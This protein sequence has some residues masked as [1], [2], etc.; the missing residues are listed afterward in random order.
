M[1]GAASVQRARTRRRLGGATAVGVVAVLAGSLAVAT[2]AS[3]NA[4]AGRPVAAPAAAPHSNGPV[5]QRPAPLTPLGSVAP[6]AD[7][8]NRPAT[9]G[10]PA[11]QAI[12]PL[13]AISP[14]PNDAPTVA[15]AA[16]PQSVPVTPAPIM[17]ATQP[18]Q[19]LVDA[20]RS[21]ALNTMAAA[22]PYV[23]GGAPAI[24]AN[25]LQPQ[26][27]SAQLVDPGTPAS[28]TQLANALLSGN[29]P[30]DLPVDPLALLQKLPNGVPQVT[31]R[32][33]SES[34]TKAASCTISLP[35]GVPALVNVT[36][37][38]TAASPDRTPDVLADL[39]P[40]VSLDAIVSATKKL[41]S[42]QA[43]LAAAKAS[44]T[45]LLKALLDPKYLLTHPGALLQKLD[46]QNLVASLTGLVQNELQALIGMV[47]VGLGLLSVRT[48]TSEI[49]AGQPLAAHV[50]AVYD[51]PGYH[52]L[53]IGYDGY[54]RGT[55]LSK[56]T[57]GIFTFN[58]A[59][60]AQGVYDVHA[61]MYN[62]GAASALA[63]TAGIS[64]ITQ[65]STGTAFD[66]T[67]ASARFSPVPVKFAA[68]ALINPGVE[69][70]TVEAQVS[71]RSQ[72][73]ALV[74]ANRGSGGGSNDQYLQVKIDT[75][76]N[77]VSAT[78]HR[79]TS[80]GSTDVTYRASS[81]IDD[82]LFANYQFGGTTLQHALQAD[83][84]GVPASIDL[85]ISTGGS[86]TNFGYTASSSL[87][88]LALGFYDQQSTMS[89]TSGPIV[90]RGALTQLPTHITGVID[91]DAKHVAITADKPLGTA[92][93]QA[94]FK[95]GAYAPLP[96]DHA[97][98]IGT[99]K[100]F[101]VDA[102]ISGFQAVDLYY[103]DHPRVTTTFSPGGQPFVAAGL[104]DDITKFRADI[105]NI[106]A[107]MSIDVDPAD[108]TAD[109]T[110][111]TTIDEIRAAY[112]NASTGPSIVGHLLGLPAHVH[113]NWTL[114]SSPHI[115]YE[116]TSS[117]P[118]AEFFASPQGVETLAPLGNDYLSA[119]V[120]DIP[121]TLDVLVDIANS[122]VEGNSSGPVGDIVVAARVPFLGQEWTAV[123]ELHQ[124]PALF[125][126]DFASG[127]YDF[128]AL[129]GP[130]G[131]AS[132]TVSNHPNP[133]EPT[134]PAHLALH[135]DEVSG[136]IDA[137]ASILNLT[138]VGYTHSAGG[139]KLTLQ[140]DEGTNPMQIDA[141]VVLKANNVADTELVA[142]GSVTGLPSHLDITMT[143]G[144]IKYTAD[145][146]LGIELG[147]RAGK[148]KALA[149]LGAPLP[150]NGIAAVV[151]TC[152]TGP[153]CAT[154]STP[155]CPAFTQCLGG[156]ANISLAGLP[157][158]VD[159][160]TG[161]GTVGFTDYQ[162]AAGALS[163]Y[164]RLIGVLAT[165]P[166]VSALATL[167]DLPAQLDFVAGPF[168]FGTGSPATID[169]GYHASAPLGTLT[170]DVN[171]VTTNATFPVL[172]ANATIAEL[173][174]SMHV[175]GSLGDVNHITVTDSD[176]ISSVSATVTNATSGYLTASIT[177]VPKTMD[178]V[179][180][181]P[182]SHAEATM[183]SPI[184]AINVL[185]HVPYDGRTWS[186]FAQAT[187]IPGHFTADFGGG[188]FGFHALSGRL[189]SA[190]FAV[191][192]H[193]GATVPALTGYL[194]A[195]YDQLSGDLDGGARVTQLRTAA[196]GRN[197]A[198]NQTFDLDI[199][200]DTVGLD[201]DVVQA[202]NGARDTRFSVGGTLTTPNTV[203]VD[204][205]DSG[206]IVYQADQSAA[207]LLSAAVGKV[208]A[209]AGL[210]API[211]SQGVAAR[212]RGCSAGPG[213]AN[214]SGVF[215]S[216]F[217]S[218][219]GAV[220]N[221]NLPGLPTKVDID[222]QAGT[223]DLVGLHPT[224][225][226]KVFAELDGLLGGDLPRVRALA[227]IDGLP[228]L[229][230]LKVGPFGADP[231]DPT[232]FRAGYSA[233]HGLGHLQVD[234]DADTT[235]S[236]GTIRGQLI[237]SNL[238][239]SVSVAGT[240][241]SQ[242]H[243]DVVDPGGIGELR[244][245]AT[246]TLGGVPGSALVDF[247]DIPGAMHMDIGSADTAQGV[248]APQFTYVGCQDN[249]N[250]C[251]SPANTLDGL[252]Q[253]DA[254]LSANVGPGSVGTNGAFFRF[255]NLGGDT[256][257][258]LDTANYHLQLTSVPQT[259]SFQLGLNIQIGDIPNQDFSEQ[260]FDFLDTQGYVQGHYGLRP[261]HIGDIEMS[262]DNLKSLLLQPGAAPFGLPALVGLLFPGVSGDYG[263]FAM[264][265]FDVDVNP[266]VYVKIH[267]SPPVVP[268][269][270]PVD[271]T[272]PSH[273]DSFFFHKYDMNGP[274]NI[275]T[276]SFIDV[277]CF[278]VTQEP[279]P[280]G[281][282]AN[283]VTLSGSDGP[284]TF[285][286][287]DYNDELPDLLVNVLSAY[288]SPFGHKFDY[289][290]DGC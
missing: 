45:N 243:I 289:N 197:A 180:D 104:I 13:P 72:L 90:A 25:K 266:D 170:V 140:A 31:Y 47:N 76:P 119:A 262:V 154:D 34:A 59:A 277:V 195:H 83:A 218:C 280:R 18:G 84:V 272:L 231:A 263:T 252:V 224:G 161:V 85:G 89:G 122:H 259:D 127:N 184:G 203:H 287:I 270:D 191:T 160:D 186:A 15:R 21:D 63:V 98:Y 238:P 68:H 194:T 58:P 37:N 236:L 258:R 121:T 244:V 6:G 139:Q 56:G 152:A 41:T 87:D 61:E 128:H 273:I 242:N 65:D 10:S 9:T 246:A 71:N 288:M 241:G 221:V 46:L 20:A 123:G 254:R 141:D 223:V 144:T 256:K 174:A 206:H 120:T 251:T 202:A 240:F 101:G 250:P 284:Q 48:G 274:G 131:A 196:Y 179:V 226:L 282:S 276:V 229:L 225:T 29:L 67:V 204:I 283:G 106:P 73:D 146:H 222:T 44:L 212:A 190:T 82:V 38:G 138:E 275:L 113:A 43:D 62:G 187:T 91:T 151:R 253:V 290:V 164:L 51:I 147:I 100:A 93:L 207:L 97:T 105:S 88:T 55:G 165:V 64:S 248:N 200:A 32:I 249:S 8:S 70:D 14:G 27:S 99:G 193:D 172:R 257:V 110:A 1:F 52:R 77:T 118:F 237:A 233:S 42:D 210:G 176:A 278:N 79:P 75:L 74:F 23:S 268:D 134:S 50:W 108:G 39:V 3:A 267:V 40:A 230:D 81:T 201:A 264:N 167:S 173:P 126:A 17:L 30:P 279:R 155:F 247:T 78:L 57:L 66:P 115:R 26:V 281:K 208:A 16:V 209:L 22:G 214:D 114:G 53:S 156:V 95:L 69:E 213:C 271:Y 158:E 192:N 228:P 96:G 181:V 54:R 5:S 163:I 255:T 189:G 265:M 239:Q 136:D 148:S 149:G 135:Y 7:G 260:I 11:L 145:K 235:S 286:F 86:T 24:D 211:Y 227:T 216:V 217:S 125:T 132:L 182:N 28:L 111:S 261:S 166:D 185:A 12:D 220:A 234:A 175:H 188:S 183:S 219:F 232:K 199:G 92:T 285:N 157:T 4:P 137:S 245:Q 169:A 19:T 33:C 198:G 153:G 142:V 36:G 133:L 178:Y 143:D 159:V 168:T 109:Y 103:D 102:R 171:A 205:A 35:L 269:F 49:P 80:G 129:S 130:L 112:V 107:S 60:I 150:A 177:G 116:A 215:C 2:P 117:I 124:V 94:S 162:P